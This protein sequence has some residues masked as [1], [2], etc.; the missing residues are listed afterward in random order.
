MEGVIERC[1]QPAMLAHVCCCSAFVLI[2]SQLVNDVDEEEEDNGDQGDSPSIRRGHDTPRGAPSP[3]GFY[4]RR[5]EHI[6]GLDYLVSGLICSDICFLC[7]VGGAGA[8]ATMRT[9]LFMENEQ[10]SMVAEFNIQT[11]TMRDLKTQVRFVAV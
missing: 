8:S 11:G 4:P 10:D 1:H 6:F 9:I 3:V 5:R 7:Q 2:P